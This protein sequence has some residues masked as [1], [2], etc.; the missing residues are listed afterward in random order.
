MIRA[1]LF[2]QVLQY[3]MDNPAASIEE[4]CNKVGVSKRTFYSWV[5]SDSE[6]MQV[7]KESLND[8]Q[9]GALF[10]YSQRIY[11]ALTMLLDDAVNKGI[12]A[13]TRLKILRF[14]IPLFDDFAKV[15]HATPG[16][17]DQAPFLK[18]GPMLEHAQSRF[19][20]IDLAMTEDGVHIEVSKDVSVIDGLAQDLPQV[21]HPDTNPPI[22]E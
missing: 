21:E 22:T 16:T 13:E 9:R 3:R 10:E 5:A 12:K 18:K 8:A 11:T 15:H 17:E 19:A 6:A 20:T 4:A 14:A 7:V 1:N 2:L